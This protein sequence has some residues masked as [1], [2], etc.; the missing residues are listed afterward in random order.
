MLVSFTQVFCSQR[1]GA[2][3]TKVGLKTH[4]PEKLGHLVIVLGSLLANKSFGLVTMHIDVGDISAFFFGCFQAGTR[5]IVSGSKEI[6]SLD[7]LAAILNNWDISYYVKAPF[8]KFLL[9]VYV[10]STENTG[11]LASSLWE[12]SLQQTEWFSGLKGLRPSDVGPF[13]QTTIGF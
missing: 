1:R 12:N 2:Q 13:S 7:E 9:H 11:Q 3:L 5:Y 6:F 4:A 10:N 8:L